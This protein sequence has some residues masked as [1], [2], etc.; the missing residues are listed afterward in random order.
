MIG[1]KCCWLACTGHERLLLL[2]GE[3]DRVEGE[4]QVA[5]HVVDVLL[6]GLMRDVRRGVVG[7]DLLHVLDVGVA[8]RQ[9]WNPGYDI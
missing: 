2:G 9:L 1:T 8:Q 4:V 7:H 5:R 3:V 6:L